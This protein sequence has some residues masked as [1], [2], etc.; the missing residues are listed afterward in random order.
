MSDCH[1]KLSPSK[2]N[3]LRPCLPVLFPF[4]ILFQGTLSVFQ[5]A[6]FE[7]V[8]SKYVISMLRAVCKG[9]SKGFKVIAVLRLL[10]ELEIAFVARRLP[11]S[12]ALICP[13]NIFSNLMHAP[14]GAPLS[15]PFHFAHITMHFYHQ[16]WNSLSCLM[17][18]HKF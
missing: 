2:K 5:S 10:C 4:A 13:R 18:N 1:L 12:P 6:D 15:A 8:S 11:K 14:L 16:A 7:V 3:P 17:I 9:W